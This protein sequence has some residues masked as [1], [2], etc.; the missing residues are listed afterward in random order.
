MHTQPSDRL[1][2]YIV[3]AIIII[4]ILTIKGVRICYTKYV[5]RAEIGFKEKKR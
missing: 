4:G 5:K 1:S 2:L 3:S